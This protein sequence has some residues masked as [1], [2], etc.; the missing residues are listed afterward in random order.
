MKTNKPKVH[1][2]DAKKAGKKELSKTLTDRF[3]QLM[4]EMGQEAEKSGVDI[5]KVGLSAIKKL[6]AKLSV[7][8]PAKKKVVL[9]EKQAKKAVINDLKTMKKAVAGEA[10]VAKK[11]PEIARE[12]I[13]ENTVKKAVTK[14]R[15][16]AQSVKVTPILSEENAVKALAKK[17]AVKKTTKAPRKTKTDEDVTSS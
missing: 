4:K 12:T 9:Q 17:T 5:I 2:K 15:P 16:A 3:L 10:K 11:K 7:G 13:T 14:A 8:K 1:K 6:S